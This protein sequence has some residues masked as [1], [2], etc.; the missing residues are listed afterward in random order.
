MQNIENL[1]DLITLKKISETKFSGKNYKPPWNRVFGGQ[2][3]A[4]SL[5]AAYR[6]VDEKRFDACMRKQKKK[7][8]SAGKFKI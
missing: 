2:V 6:T 8:K 4:Q 5:N 7:A 1:I 3:L